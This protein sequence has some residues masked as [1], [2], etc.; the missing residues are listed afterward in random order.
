MKLNFLKNEALRGVYKKTIRSILT[1][2]F[3]LAGW[4]LWIALKIVDVLWI[5]AVY[6]FIENEIRSHKRNKKI[7]GRT[8]ALKKIEKT[9]IE[10]NFLEK[11]KELW[12]EVGKARK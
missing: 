10:D 6:P 9:I 2:V 5:V 11:T 4:K 8:L 1:G 12:K 7:K 3:K